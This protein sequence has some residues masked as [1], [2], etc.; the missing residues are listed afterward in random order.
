MEDDALDIESSDGGELDASDKVDKVI[1][2]TTQLT[3]S[4]LQRYA[5][6]DAVTMMKN[7][8]L[9]AFIKSDVAEAYGVFFK[10]VSASVLVTEEAAV[11]GSPVKELELP[12]A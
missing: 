1:S 8:A 7:P 5:Q 10:A 3:L 6:L 9:A 12:D 2:A 11:V 4:Y